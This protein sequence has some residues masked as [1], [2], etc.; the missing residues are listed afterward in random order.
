MLRFE[1]KSLVAALVGSILPLSV[2][3]MSVDSG[4]PSDQARIIQQDQEYLRQLNFPNDS[5][6]AEARYLMG[7]QGQLSSKSLQSWLDERVSVVVSEGLDLRKSILVAP[8]TVT[9]P[10]AKIFPDREARVPV[11]ADSGPAP[12]PKPG[13]S[14][15][16]ESHPVIVMANMGAAVYMMGKQSEQ[17]L[18]LR[19]S[20]NSTMGIV[21]PHHGFI[22]IGEGLFMERMRVNPESAEMPAN[23]IARLAVFFHEAR[24]SDGHGK[25][26]SF[27]H[28]YCP[29]GHAY[30]GY[31]ACDRNLNGPYTVG[32]KML[33]AMGHACT[34]CSVKDKTA[35]SL[36]QA[37]SMSR[38]L[39]FQKDGVTPVKMWSPKFEQII[40]FKPD[41]KQ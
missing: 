14:I 26:L 11:P 38:I 16:T 32:A 27:G 8:G 37:D 3:A 28:A 19:L 5:I 29:A 34:D 2:M 6:S 21:S 39:K 4:V 10:E 18:G 17:L 13:N 35:L 30:A 31:P 7:I 40:S 1:K 24:H 36:M 15:R 12:T 9:Y 20:D 41:H 33:K 23:R 25:S 22:Q